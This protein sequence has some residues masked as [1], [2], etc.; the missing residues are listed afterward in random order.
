[1]TTN[2]DKAKLQI[3]SSRIKYKTLTNII[4]NVHGGLRASQIKKRQ[5]RVMKKESYTI[6]S[7]SCTYVNLSTGLKGREEIGQ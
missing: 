2:Y 4:Q 5:L 6:S 1:M 3:M 7:N